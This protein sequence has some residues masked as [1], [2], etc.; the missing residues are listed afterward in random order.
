MAYIDLAQLEKVHTKASSKNKRLGSSV[1][2]RRMPRETE[3]PPLTMID[4]KP[5]DGTNTSKK[6]QLGH[7]TIKS[8]F[9]FLR[10]LYLHSPNPLTE[11]RR[12]IEDFFRQDHHGGMKVFSPQSFSD[13]DFKWFRTHEKMVV[14][15]D[16]CCKNGVQRTIARVLV[17][18]STLQAY[19][20]PV[21]CQCTT[22]SELA[23]HLLC[24][25]L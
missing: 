23:K 7:G 4:E 1:S 6:D 8:E 21:V 12:R 14:Q 20:H 17:Y 25:Q 3:K 16:T 15:M 5:T 10:S 9:F 13:V 19:L 2:Q 22:L 18:F 24:F 11:P